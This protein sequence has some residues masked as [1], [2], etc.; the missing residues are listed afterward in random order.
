[1]ADADDG[2]RDETCGTVANLR[3]VTQA[4]RFREFAG[5]DFGRGYT[6]AKS[7]SRISALEDTAS[8]VS[9]SHRRHALPSSSRRTAAEIPSL[10][11]AH[12]A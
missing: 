9:S 1:M 8:V 7:G 4:Y 5:L 6:T 2:A 12:H 3:N 11:F 10:R